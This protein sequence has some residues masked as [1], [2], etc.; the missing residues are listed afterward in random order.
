MIGRRLLPAGF[1]AAANGHE[2]SVRDRGNC[3]RMVTPPRPV[4]NESHAHFGHK[5]SRRGFPQL[6]ALDDHG[7][8][9]AAA[10]A[11]AGQA[12]LQ[13]AIGQGVEQRHQ[14]AAP[15]APIG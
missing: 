3:P 11:E 2:I 7:H 8:G 6:F 10:Q 13:A 12:A 15:L 14:H 9:V 4:A 1:G 5:D